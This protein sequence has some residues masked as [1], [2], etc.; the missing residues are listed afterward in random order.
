M[1][2]PSSLVSMVNFSSSSSSSE[3]SSEEET[4]APALQMFAMAYNRLQHTRTPST[5]RSINRNHEAAHQRLMDDYFSENPLYGEEQ[6]CMLVLFYINMILKD[7]E[8]AICPFK[9]SDLPP[10]QERVSQEEYIKIFQEKYETRKNTTCLGRISWTTSG[11]SN[12][13]T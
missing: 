8:H 9:E 7:E 12:Y 1:D 10:S 5:R 3:E 13:P 6:S 2:S 11:T 4:I